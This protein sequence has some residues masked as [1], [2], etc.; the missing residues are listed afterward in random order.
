MKVNKTTIHFELTKSGQYG[1][2]LPGW[3][4]KALYKQSGFR[5][6][7]RRLVK[8]AVKREFFNELK[9]SFNNK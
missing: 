9:K 5:S 4:W 2:T 3:F 8:K 6:K 7:K 1:I